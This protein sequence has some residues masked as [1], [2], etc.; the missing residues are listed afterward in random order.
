[1]YQREESLATKKLAQSGS[2]PSDTKELQDRMS[3][4]QSEMFRLECQR[5]KL[6]YMN[7]RNSN[8]DHTLLTPSSDIE[9]RLLIGSNGTHN[10][11]SA[12]MNGESNGY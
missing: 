9:D 1:L 4:L 7:M 5:H 8:N 11:K 6:D 12:A 2:E 10:G 3:E